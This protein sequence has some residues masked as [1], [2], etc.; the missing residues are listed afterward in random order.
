MLELDNVIEE[1]GGTNI[2]ATSWAPGFQLFLDWMLWSVFSIGLEG[3]YSRMDTEATYAQ[4]V[5]TGELDYYQVGANA[6]LYYPGRTFRPYVTLGLD[7]TWNKGDFVLDPPV[8]NVLTE[9]RVHKTR[10]DGIGAGFDWN[11]TPPTNW[12]L[13]LEGRYN[14]TFD[15]Q[16]ADEHIRWKLAFLWYIGGANRINTSERGGLYE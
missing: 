8:G 13:R 4:G 7:R 5:Q 12:G 10:R 15:D 16:D 6:K 1:T 14:T 9:H 11:P 3:G 2:D